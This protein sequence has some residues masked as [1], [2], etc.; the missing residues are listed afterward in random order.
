VAVQLD[1]LADDVFAA[2]A[3]QTMGS[4]QS[5]REPFGV[6]IRNP[7]YPDLFFMNGIDGLKAPS[8]SVSELETTLREALP[9]VLNLIMT[10]RDPETIAGLGPRLDAAG[11]RRE[12]LVAM[13]QVRD[14]DPLP[15]LKLAV[16]EVE[17]SQHWQDFEE[18]VRT[19]TAE[20]GRSEAMTTQRI[21][22]YRWRA[23]NAPQH[24]FI[25][26]DD[27]DAVARV[28]FYQH[29]ANAYVHA[30]YTHPAA[31]RRG[32]GSALTVAM[33]ERAR[34][35]GS[36]RLTLQCTKGTNLPAFYERL[37]FRIVGE[38]SMWTRPS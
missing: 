4:G 3:A 12:V 11:Y 34:A 26:Y 38:Q 22:L 29:G 7:D 33:S 21:A 31:R 24:L 2:A 10:S 17:S 20:R 14:P 13:V 8:W 6:V 25:A 35:I 18:L 23:A 15:C 32:I 16:A 28:G 27:G 30:M 37:G 36:E 1:A 9:G 19:D 5:R